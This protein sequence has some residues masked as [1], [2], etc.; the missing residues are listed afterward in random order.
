MN[1]NTKHFHEPDECL[2]RYKVVIVKLQGFD[3]G[4]VLYQLQD[5]QL[6]TSFLWSKMG[7]PEELRKVIL[8]PTTTGAY[9]PGN[10]SS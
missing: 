2:S 3:R 6:W 9:L 1:Q 8:A 5:K 7:F 10:C 4:L